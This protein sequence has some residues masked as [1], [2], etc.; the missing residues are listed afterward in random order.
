MDLINNAMQGHSAG[1]KS[2][3]DERMAVL[4]LRQLCIV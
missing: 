4:P 1:A 3:R 2:R